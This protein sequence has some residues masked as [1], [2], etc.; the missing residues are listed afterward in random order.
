LLRVV[1]ELAKSQPAESA[2]QGSD[3][4][5]PAS[6]PLDDPASRVAAQTQPSEA[7][8][9]AKGDLEGS[10]STGTN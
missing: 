4:L 10:T 3:L 6:G 5:A 9:G 8:G 2:Q 7:Q 1:D